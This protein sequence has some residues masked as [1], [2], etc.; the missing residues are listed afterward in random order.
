MSVNQSEP[1]L[2]PSFMDPDAMASLFNQ[3]DDPF[4]KAPF[5]LVLPLL[6]PTILFHLFHYHQRGLSLQQTAT[7]PSILSWCGF[8]WSDW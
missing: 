2:P 5:N 3:N 4:T 1:R 7:L 8:S 6:T